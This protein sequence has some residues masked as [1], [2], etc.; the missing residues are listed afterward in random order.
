MLGG[1]VLPL[2]HLPGPVDA[3]A[4]DLP[5]AVLTRVLTIGLGSPGDA[6]EPLI[7]LA[8]WAVVF[9]VLAARRFR[10]D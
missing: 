4:S 8:G 5:A 1:I 10:W 2:D 3:L 6:A 7:L 9:A